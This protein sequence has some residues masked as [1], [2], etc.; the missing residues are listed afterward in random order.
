MKRRR[1]STGEKGEKKAS[2]ALRSISKR[3]DIKNNTE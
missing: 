2:L 1:A 3:R